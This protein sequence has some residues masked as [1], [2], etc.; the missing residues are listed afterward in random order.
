MLVL[1]DHAHLISPARRQHPYVWLRDFILAQTRG[2][3]E[4]TWKKCG[5]I[6]IVHRDIDGRPVG[7]GIDKTNRLIQAK[8]QT[9]ERNLSRTH[10]QWRTYTVTSVMLMTSAGSY[11]THNLQEAAP[12]APTDGLRSSA[13]R[14]HSPPTPIPLLSPLSPPRHPLLPRSVPLPRALD[15]TVDGDRW[16]DTISA[17]S[18]ERLRKEIDDEFRLGVATRRRDSG[19]RPPGELRLETRATVPSGLLLAL[20]SSTVPLALMSLACLPRHI[21]HLVQTPPEPINFT[22]SWPHRSTHHYVGIYYVELPISLTAA[23]AQTLGVSSQQAL[24][25]AK[26]QLGV[27]SD[28]WLNGRVRTGL[29]ETTVRSA[30]YWRPTG[31]GEGDEPQHLEQY[32]Q[33]EAVEWE[34]VQENR[35]LPPAATFNTPCVTNPEPLAAQKSAL[36]IRQFASGFFDIIGSQLVTQGV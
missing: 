8:V 1:K 5:S 6:V 36:V 21:Q 35:G 14:A 15:E 20:A 24:P 23:T 18:K 13:S 22:N 3:D 34:P 12:T 4:D 26:E 29:G 25:S 27:E 28:L 10:C 31:S 19:P 11:I 32:D 9:L 33:L 16:K 30:V 17:I 7:R 2:Y